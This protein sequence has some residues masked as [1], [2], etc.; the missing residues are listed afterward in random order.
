V[1]GAE[2]ASQKFCSD[3][4]GTGADAGGIAA[5]GG[6]ADGVGFE[7]SRLSADSTFGGVGGDTN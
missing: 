4:F 5:K 3:G 6:A 7:G 2:I 1:F